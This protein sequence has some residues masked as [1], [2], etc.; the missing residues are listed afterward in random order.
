MNQKDYLTNKSFCPIPWTGFY[1]DISGD[2]KNCICSYESIGN[3][4]EN[5]IEEILLGEKNTQIK[6]EILNKSEPYSCGYCYSLDKNKKSLNVVSSR[7]YY[8]RELKTVPIDTYDSPDNFQLNQIDVRWSN[9]CNHACV[10]CG[11][12][13]SSKWAAELNLPIER[14]NVER[15][16]E[17]K[18]YIFSNIHQLKNV[19]LAGGEPLLMKENE[20][21]LAELLKH[22]P[23][24]S[25][26]VNTNLST[27][28]TKVLR[29]ITQFKNVH[30]TVSAESVGK[31]FEYIRYGG[32]W[33]D[34]LQNLTLLK[35]TDHKITFNMVWCILNHRGIFECIDFMLD[36]GFHP[37]SFILTAIVGPGHLDVRHLPDSVL[38]SLQEELESRIAKKPGFLLEDGYVNLLKHIQTPFIKNWADTDSKLAELDASRKLNRHSIFD[39]LYKEINHGKT[40]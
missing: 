22:N 10:Y 39:T 35:Q 37:N 7:V 6:T 17:L 30:W 20:E 31:Q 24:V 27:T 32:I 23:D 28:N 4:K 8:M 16:Q 18:K 15:Q 19:Y 5:S 33:D 2:V 21:F 34:F 13:L 38:Q 25:L 40:I 12:L 14:P 29:L 1:V 9:L 3:L 26:R 36:A 11:P